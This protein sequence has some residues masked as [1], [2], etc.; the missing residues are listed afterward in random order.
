MIRKLTFICM[1]SL[2]L[3]VQAGEINRTNDSLKVIIPQTDLLKP[4]EPSYLKNVTTTS[5]WDSNWF[6]NVSGG[7]TA[8]VSNPLGCEDLFGRVK[9]SLTVSIGKWCTPAIGTRVSFQGLQ[10][11]N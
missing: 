5:G 9:P 10:S 3:G 2:T 1:C 4:V 6:L 7:A 11:M 8:F